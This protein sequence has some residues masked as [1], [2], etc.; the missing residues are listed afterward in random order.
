MVRV[1]E[2]TYN[3]AALEDQGICVHDWSFPDGEGPSEAII[4]DWLRLV[5]E[6]KQDGGVIACHCVAGLGRAPV[7][8]VIAL[9]EE[10]GLT[11]LDAITLVR[12]KRR[13]AINSRQ[14]KFLQAYKPRSNRSNRCRIN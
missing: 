1:C 13:G 6:V 2:P 14:L 4:G 9:I 3:K 11:P 10:A 12:E 8:V 5:H 7:L